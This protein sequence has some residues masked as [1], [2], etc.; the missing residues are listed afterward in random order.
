LLGNKS[1]IVILLLGNKP[2]IVILLLGNKPSIVILLLGNKPS[3]VILLPGDNPLTCCATSQ[4][5]T[6]QTNMALPKQFLARCPSCLHNFMNIYCAMTC[7]PHHSKYVYAYPKYVVPYKK[8][9]PDNS[10]LETAQILEVSHSTLRPNKQICVSG[11]P[12][13]PRF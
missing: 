12:T 11:R 5:K 2:S 1:S 7:D 6:I 13:V 8:T 10:T 3:I 9:L 4:L